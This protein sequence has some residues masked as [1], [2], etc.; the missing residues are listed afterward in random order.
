MTSYGRG[1]V[2][3][4]R[5]CAASNEWQQRNPLTPL[6][7]PKW[8]L[9]ERRL[10]MYTQE[11]PDFVS[12]RHSGGRCVSGR[13]QFTRMNCRALGTTSF[14]FWYGGFTSTAGYVP[15]NE[16]RLASGD[17]ATP[18]VII[19]SERDPFLSG[20][21][22]QA[23]RLQRGASIATANPLNCRSHT[24]RHRVRSLSPHWSWFP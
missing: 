9:E 20:R 12:R 21:L 4:K 10:R 5:N 16:A 3:V 11:S 13:R 24:A 19:S 23:F 1:G 14:G 17:C 18:R 2:G 22:E 6:R 15:V 7:P 8:F